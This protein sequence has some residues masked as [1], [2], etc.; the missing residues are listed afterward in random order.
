MYK[1][2]IQR[3]L[4]E[5]DSDIEFMRI[6][7]EVWNRFRSIFNFR[8]T[9]LADSALRSERIS[10][11]RGITTG[12]S[13]AACNRIVREQLTNEDGD[14][15]KIIESEVRAYRAN[16]YNEHRDDL[17]TVNNVVVPIK[18]DDVVPD[19][20]VRIVSELPS[21]DDFNVQ[22]G[23]RNGVITI[24]S[25]YLVDELESLLRLISYIYCY[26]SLAQI[27]GYDELSK[28]ESDGMKVLFDSQLIDFVRLFDHEKR[29]FVHELRH[30]VDSI[31]TADKHLR[32]G[33]SRGDTSA[34]HETN[35]Y[36][37]ELLQIVVDEFETIRDAANPI[38]T[39][40]KEN[41]GFR[42]LLERMRNDSEAVYRTVI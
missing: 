24:V 37:T 41:Y 36:F 26:Q 18:V 1:E 8:L 19:V 11:G 9:N 5:R 42:R 12:L 35:A 23:Y 7:D 15:N 16:P 40:T 3:L 2:F 4:T 38:E 32:R 25:R 30:F 31:T 17:L 13:A 21:R 6:S 33:F 34:G 29:T 14:I 39:L 27:D 10:D 28:T 22:G 20:T